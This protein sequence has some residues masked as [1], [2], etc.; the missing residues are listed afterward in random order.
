MAVTVSPRHPSSSND[1]GRGSWIFWGL[2]LGGLLWSPQWLSRFEIHHLFALSGLPFAPP[3][4]WMSPAISLIGLLCFSGVTQ[5]L[6][7][8]GST[9]QKRA[10]LILCSSVGGW[11]FWTMPSWAVL[12]W[13]SLMLTLYF[14][15][16]WGQWKLSIPQ[17]IRRP[18][19]WTDIGLGLCFALL[20]NLIG[21][22]PFVL[23][24]GMLVLWSKYQS[25][26]RFKLDFKLTQWWQYYQG[27]MSVTLIGFFIFMGASIFKIHPL[28]GPILCPLYLMPCELSIGQQSEILLVG[29]LLIAFPWQGFIAYGIW[30]LWP[31]RASHSKAGPLFNEEDKPLPHYLL[32][33]GLG[34]VAI[35]LFG[36][37]THRDGSLSLLLGLTLMAWIGGHVMDRSQT[38]V[39]AQQGLQ[40]LLT[41]LPILL[42]SLGI[43]SIWFILTQIPDAYIPNVTWISAGQLFPDGESPKTL[44]PINPLPMWKLGL[45]ILPL[46]CLIGSG[47][48]LAVQRQAFSLS[49]SII[50]LTSW[51]GI[52]TC[53]LFT[54]Q[55]P[56]AH[57]RYETL[58]HAR[59]NAFT[60]LPTASNTYYE[61]TVPFVF[62]TLKAQGQDIPAPHYRLYKEPSFYQSPLEKRGQA[63]ALLPIYDIELTHSP[64]LYYS[65]LD[66]L[67]LFN[68][69]E[70]HHYV[71]SVDPDSHRT[72]ET[73]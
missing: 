16:C 44:I 12:Q 50:V 58:H 24:L 6:L 34:S 18:L 13:A 57:P 36:L 56:L 30:N 46:W 1:S 33:W 62:K 19:A 23:C 72:K 54:L 8:T 69:V 14:A 49:R 27:V 22:L 38:L 39:S 48:L 10:T 43:V 21:I 31:Y 37:F 29:L 60:P 17:R 20:G 40:K 3:F 65:L 61:E 59:L 28:N 11:L 67:P 4:A 2:I 9:R 45:M 64:A 63:L 26:H 71:L 47:I 5:R 70:G 7:G 53:L 51:T 35:A 41:Y 73:P 25:S 15:L 42:L 68:H 52:Y 66:I 55:F 32:W